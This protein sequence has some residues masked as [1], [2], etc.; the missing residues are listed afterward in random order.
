MKRIYVVIL[1]LMLTGC[2]TQERIQYSWDMAYQERHISTMV[3]NAA[4][5]TVHK[6]YMN[7]IIYQDESVTRNFTI[8]VHMF[9]NESELP[10]NLR[11]LERFNAKEYS[12]KEYV[13]LGLEGNVS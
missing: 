10:E 7:F 3:K 2:A 12:E 8:I 13:P 1:L 5:L 4:D 9:N 11:G 6:G